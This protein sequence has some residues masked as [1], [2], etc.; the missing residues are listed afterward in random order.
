MDELKRCCH[1]RQY[2]SLDRFHKDRSQ[3]DGLFRRCKD[4]QRADGIRLRQTE[5]FKEKANTWKQ[6][7]RY[8][9]PEAV[10]L[11]CARRRAKKKCLPCTI[12]V[13][14][15]VIPEY[16]PILGVALVP[17]RGNRS[18]LPTAPTLDRIIPELGYVPGNV[19][20]ISHKA[21]VMK[22]DAT[23]KQ[24]KDFAD[25]VYREVIKNYV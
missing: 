10:M 25:W 2:F 13:E 16:C 14:D 12:T 6:R 18:P 5:G 19:Q 7:W 9:H 15:I 1:C 21:N 8:E 24:L 23:T 22:N 11:E 4:C 17:G 3:K 20:V